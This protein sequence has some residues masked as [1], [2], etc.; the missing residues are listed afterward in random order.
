MFR[1]QLRIDRQVLQRYYGESDAAEATVTGASSKIEKLRAQLAV[2]RKARVT[3][4]A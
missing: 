1:V 2:A 4:R 3:K